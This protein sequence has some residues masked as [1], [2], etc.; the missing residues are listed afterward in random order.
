MAHPLH[1]AIAPLAAEDFEPPRYAVT[2]VVPGDV[3]DWQRVPPIALLTDPEGEEVPP[4]R[5]DVRMVWDAQGL[6]LRARVCDDEVVSQPECEPGD[7]HFWRQ[8]H[9]EFRLARDGCGG[10]GHVQW[11]L[12]AHGRWWCSAGVIG[13]YDAKLTSAGWCGELVVPWD[14]IGTG[15]ESRRVW[16]GLAAHVRWASGAAEIACST[17]AELGFAQDARLGEF[18]LIDAPPPVTLLQWSMAD[19]VLGPGP[20]DARL[21]VENSTADPLPVTI[22]VGAHQCDTTLPLGVSTLDVPVELHRPVLRQLPVRCRIGEAT[23]DLGAVTL[24]PAPSLPRPLVPRRPLMFTPELLAEIGRKAATPRWRDWLDGVDLTPRGDVATLAA[25]APHVHASTHGLNFIAPLGGL[26]TMWLIRRDPA[27]IALA[28]EYMRAAADRLRVG[29]RIDLG[30]GNAAV[31]MAL[32][33]DAFTPHLAPGDAAVW[34]DVMGRFIDLH[35]RCA[36]ARTWPCTTIAN[37]NA[38][39]NGGA[40]L[41]AL[42]LLDTHPR[43]ACCVRL[44]LKHFRKHLD[45]CY[46]SAGGNTEGAQYWHY[47]LQQVLVFAQALR[48][49]TGDDDGILAHP[50]VTHALNMIRVGITNDGALHGANDTVPMP[51]GRDIACFLAREHGDALALWYV[52]HAQRYYARRRRAGL[53]I[54]YGEHPLLGL[55]WRPEAPEAPAD[56]ALP[57]ALALPDVEVAVLR[58][59]PRWDAAWVVGV[60]GARPPFTHHNQADAGAISVD[61]HGRRLLLDPGYFKPLAT[62]HCLPLIGGVGPAVPTT[63]T[64]TIR[65]CGSAGSLRYVLCDATAAYGGVAARVH[66]HLLMLADHGVVLVDDIVPAGE[67][68]VDVVSQLQ[69]GAPVR[70]DETARVLDVCDGAATL[71]M[72]VAAPAEVSWRLSEE[73]SLHDT[74]WGYHFADCRLFPVTVAYTSAASR[75]LVVVM[76]DGGAATSARCVC[77]GGRVEVAL[78]PIEAALVECEAGWVLQ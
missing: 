73:R 55:L 44:A 36:T 11:I 48:N 35:V 47:A 46:G 76:T 54:P 65:A 74:H 25:A 61:L 22:T 71:R 8:D 34:R 27:L 16:R 12:T 70:L 9:V 75:P 18:V 50:A 68:P 40:G 77:S 24:R 7:P 21:T 10:A 51:V 41:I 23:H 69:C 38:I 66:R 28:C 67:A 52:D 43:A 56:A 42:A 17:P 20:Q 63:W 60:K 29:D 33:Y 39:T 72:H 6:R 30:E 4:R 58:S 31:G 3:V 15:A 59:E 62:D 5:A 26:L 53:P 57:V 14:H 78:G 1:S 19:A 45:Y 64:A 32:A 49:I 13:R 37:A 2:P